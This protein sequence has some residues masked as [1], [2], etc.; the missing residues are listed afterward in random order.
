MHNQLR[1]HIGEFKRQYN[2]MTIYFVIGCY[3]CSLCLEC[4]LAR[5]KLEGDP[6]H[7]RRL[8]SRRK[9]R[10]YD[11]RRLLLVKMAGLQIKANETRICL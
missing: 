10:Y 7:T 2:F 1:R 5:C 3:Y 11:Y 8:K 9:S 6:P 4:G